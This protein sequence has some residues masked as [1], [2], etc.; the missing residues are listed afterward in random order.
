MT[1]ASA[2]QRFNGK[3]AIVT[4]AGAGIARPAAA[5]F[6]REARSSM[7]SISTDRR[8]ASARRCPVPR[9]PH[10]VAA[11]VSKPGDIATSVDRVPDGD[12]TWTCCQQRGINMAKRIL[13]LDIGD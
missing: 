4:G 9:A 2:Q 7:G 6:A 11:D 1:S 13:E 8:G 5:A 10:S 3:V 12:R